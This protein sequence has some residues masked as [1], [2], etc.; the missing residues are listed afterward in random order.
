MRRDVKKNSDI[1]KVLKNTIKT[2]KPEFIEVIIKPDQKIIPKLQFGNPIEDI[3]PLLP[4]EEFLKN[5]LIK[6][7][8]RSKKI[9]EAN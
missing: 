2:N 3:S 9:F 5:M 4:R 8:E 6:T 1:N 7:A